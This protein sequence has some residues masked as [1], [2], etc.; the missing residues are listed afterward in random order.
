MLAA[1][2][3]GLLWKRDQGAIQGAALFARTFL[4]VSKEDR[5]IWQ[6]TF[7][8]FIGISGL[9]FALSSMLAWRMKRAVACL[10]IACRALTDMPT[11][12]LVAIIPVFLHA[13]FVVWWIYV[14]TLLWTSGDLVERRLPDDEALRAR[15][16]VRSAS[17][18]Q[19]SLNI[20]EADFPSLPPVDSPARQNLACAADPYCYYTMQWNQNLYF[21][22]IMHYFGFLWTSAFGISLCYVILSSVFSTYYFRVP[23]DKRLLPATPVLRGTSTTFR[24]HLGSIALGSFLL[25]FLQIFRLPFEIIDHWAKRARAARRTSCCASLGHFLCICGCYCVHPVAQLVHRYTFVALASQGTSY[26]EASCNAQ[27][28]A[29]QSEHRLAGIHLVCGGL[30]FLAKVSVAVGSALAA[31]LISFTEYYTDAAKHPRTALSSPLVPVLFA[32]FL[33]FVVA[34][35]VFL[36]YEAAVDSMLFYYLADCEE[37]AGAPHPV[38]GELHRLIQSSLGRSKRG[39]RPGPAYAN[40]DPESEDDS[41]AQTE[42][43]TGEKGR[44]G[45]SPKRCSMP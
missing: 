5:F 43:A 9:L 7:Y 30:F 18:L 15:A 11:T 17:V 8:V 33:G 35:F 25:S 19:G 32:G 27:R 44:V 28:I 31:L 37:G 40:P 41:E 42:A 4:D 45:A 16:S 14:A 2:K 1:Q 20:S 24:Y 22:S 38:S 10:R 3:A 29:A 13:A 6:I 26:V 12:F 23:I 36:V 34:S 21:F 39:P